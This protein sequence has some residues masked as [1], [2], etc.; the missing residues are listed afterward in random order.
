NGGYKPGPRL[1][2]RE[3]IA[4]ERKIG[5]ELPVSYRT[6]LTD[7]GHGGAGPLSGLWELEKAVAS[8]GNGSVS[9]P[10]RRCGPSTRRRFRTRRR[11]TRRTGMRTRKF[12]PSG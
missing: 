5:T 2:E 11:S 3:V 6:F 8:T 4:F 10:T 9:V 1:S 7:V 12:P